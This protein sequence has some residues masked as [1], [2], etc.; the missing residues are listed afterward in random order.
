MGFDSV[1]HWDLYGLAFSEMDP[2]G[3]L[4]GQPDH[5]G[6]KAGG[7]PGGEIHQPFG[8]WS[9]PP[10]PEVDPD[11]NIG[12]RCNV[13]VAWEGGQPHLIAGSDPRFIPLLP[14][15]VKGESG[16]YGSKGNFV[17][18]QVDGGVTMYT[19]ADGTPTGQV[20]YR[21]A[22]PDNFA[23]VAPWGRETFDANGKRIVTASGARF[24][25]GGIAGLPD[26]VSVIG[27]YIK[28]SAG[29]V[30]LEGTVIT[31]GPATGISDAIAKATPVTAVF[32]AL[33]SVVAIL[34]KPGSLNAPPSGGAVVLSPDLLDALS[35][36]GTA[37]TSAI[38]ATPSS[39]ATVV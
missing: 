20:V 17:R 21:R 29:T 27:S 26:P 30:R 11:G 12:R 2:D 25:M 1:L 32:S 28:L 23:D 10:D 6:E 4:I 33:G 7:G 14:N 39:S 5:Y 22:A 38:S 15:R 16:I 24:V 13:F 8:F 9:N 18:C 36:L 35:A 37:I 31:I 3:F 34:A 19:T